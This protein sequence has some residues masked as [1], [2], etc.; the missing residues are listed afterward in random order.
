MASPMMTGSPGEHTQKVRS[1]GKT[2]THTYTHNAGMHL[3]TQAHTHTH[4][5]SVIVLRGLGLVLLHHTGEAAVIGGG[6]GKVVTLRDR[7]SPVVTK[8]KTTS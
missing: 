4:H 3:H 7:L 2:R 1:M 8:S 5:A 6:A